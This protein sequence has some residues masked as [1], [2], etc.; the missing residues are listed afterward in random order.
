ML[1]Q[2]S[3]K[4][5]L[6][7]GTQ[8]TQPP[9]LLS[10]PGFDSLE[11]HQLLYRHKMEATIFLFHI[12]LLAK[13]VLCRSIIKSDT[14][15]HFLKLNLSP[16]YRKNTISTLTFWD[17]AGKITIARPSCIGLLSF[18]QGAQVLNIF[19]LCKR[20]FENPLIGFGMADRRSVAAVSSFVI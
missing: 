17:K 7:M 20:L 16:L 10:N 8:L 3:T 18:F 15:F 9:A 11:N 14:N 6:K 5:Q 13:P 12:H 2:H 1:P 19:F 4:C